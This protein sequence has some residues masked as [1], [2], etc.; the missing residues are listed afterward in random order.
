MAKE[1]FASKKEYVGFKTVIRENRMRI[2]EFMRRNPNASSTE[3]IEKLNKTRVAK[4]PADSL[5]AGGVA[6][7]Y[8]LVYDAI[9]LLNKGDDARGIPL[10]D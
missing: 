1:S 5:N 2:M 3:I 4:P 10:I 9:P 8:E 7:A 6:A